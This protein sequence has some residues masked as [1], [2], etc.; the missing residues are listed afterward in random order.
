M[1]VAGHAGK[2]YRDSR[3]HWT[4]HLPQCFQ[5]GCYPCGGR[6][7]DKSGLLSIVSHHH[8]AQMWHP[9]DINLKGL[10]ICQLVHVRNS[11]T[12]LQ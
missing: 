6:E 8:L 3:E 11:W 1:V 2:Q 9:A 7:S 12:M 4:S 10:H 5:P